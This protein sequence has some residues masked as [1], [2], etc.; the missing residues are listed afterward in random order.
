[1]IYPTDEMRWDDAVIV[2]KMEGRNRNLYRR[3]CAKITSN[4]TVK[5]DF[6]FFLNYVYLTNKNCD[7]SDDIFWWECI[8]LEEHY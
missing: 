4:H 2:K 8:L 3:E 1:M 6:F 5:I 7:V